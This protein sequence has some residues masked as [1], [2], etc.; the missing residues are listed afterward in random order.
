MDWIES[1]YDLVGRDGGDITWWQMT[2]RGVVVFFYGLVLVRFAGQRV[3]G[4][5]AAFDIVLAVLIGSNLSRTLTANAPFVPTLAATAGLVA[6][7]WLITRLALRSYVVGWLVKGK[8]V[9]LVRDGDIDW[10]AM[11]RGGIGQGDADEAMRDAGVRGVRWT[12]SAAS[13]VGAIPVHDHSA[14]RGS[15]P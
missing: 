1:F 15:S 5:A 6:L 4:K 9:Q 12:P 14:V 11:R 10:Q 8:V 13:P 7:H 2:I 3:F